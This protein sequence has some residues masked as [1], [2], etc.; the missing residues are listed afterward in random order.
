MRLLSKHQDSESRRSLWRLLLVPLVV[1]TLGACD[2]LLEVDLPGGVTSA[3]LNNP[4]LAETLVLGAVGDFECGLTDY[5]WFPGQWYE[6]FLNTSASRPDALSGLRSQLIEVYADPCDSG[7]GPIWTVM[8]VPRAQA[9]R[10]FDLITS[11][12]NVSNKNTL[13]ATAKLY[14][15]YS[16]QLIAEQFC[17]LTIAGGPRLSREAG[18][19][20]AEE[21]FTAAIGLATAAPDILAAAHIGRARARLNAGNNSAGVI[22]DAG[23]PAVSEG[24][25]LVATYD[26]SPGRRN[27]RITERN[28]LAENQ[29]PHSRYGCPSDAFNPCPDGVGYL[30]FGPNGE[31]TQDGA[32]LIGDGVIDPRVPIQLRDGGGTLDG[33]GTLEYREQLKYPTEATPIPFS[34]WREAQLMIAEATGG[35]AAVD[36]INMLRTNPAGLPQEIDAGAWPLPTFSSSDPAEIMATVIEER[37]RELWMHGVEFG[38]KLRTGYPAWQDSDEYGQTLG[39]GRCI[40]IPF[41]EETSNPNL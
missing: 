41:L 34:T 5:L 25:Q 29:M 31:V 3:A 38:D 37:R 1:M 2:E 9:V 33:R 12:E 10:A 17:E 22:S 19:A 36:I 32:P 27:N 6:I 24:F 7:T 8:Q 15:G 16:I 14:E 20:A 11:F 13:L 21:R 39:E 18:F 35:Q 30:T 28:N 40:R 4:E 23:N 26:L